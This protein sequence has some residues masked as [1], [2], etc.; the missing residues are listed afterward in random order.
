MKRKIFIILIPVLFVML[1]V[2]FNT[3]KSND[4]LPCNIPASEYLD[5]L[6]EADVILD[7]RT[8]AEYNAGHLEN[9]VLIDIRQ[10]DFNEKIGKL[11][12]DKRY[13]VYCRTGR[14][15]ASATQ[16]MKQM[17]F[18]NVCNVEGGVVML[19]RNGVKLTQ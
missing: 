19:T 5:R 9:A 1:M 13:F 3:S 4:D 15:S 17:G 16:I 7:V 6:P 12:K 14:R 8:L 10:P 11:N 2:R 18:K